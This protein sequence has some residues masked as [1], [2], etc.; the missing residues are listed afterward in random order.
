MAQKRGCCEK[1]EL[2]LAEWVVRTWCLGGRG[3]SACKRRA[4]GSHAV[5]GGRVVWAPQGPCCVGAWKA[6]DQVPLP[7]PLPVGS[8]PCQCPSQHSQPLALCG[9][10]ERSTLLYCGEK[11]PRAG[12]SEHPKTGR[13]GRNRNKEM[14]GHNR[15]APVL[16]EGSLA[17]V[18]QT[19]E[20]LPYRGGPSHAGL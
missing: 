9:S 12:M 16:M 8:Q 13:C 1:L 4:G 15:A 18:C 7:V 3:G 10:G 14:A 5:L 20:L 6:K 11:Q 2:L 17:R 19:P